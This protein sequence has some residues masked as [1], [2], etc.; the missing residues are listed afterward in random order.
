MMHIDSTAIGHPSKHQLVAFAETLVDKRAPV[1]ALLAAHVT[2]CPVCAHEVKQIR[3]SFELAA[4]AQL[5]EPS[6][7]LTQQILLRARNERQQSGLQT[8][9][10]N[11]F[12]YI[13][14]VAACLIAAFALAYFSFTTALNDFSPERKPVLQVSSPENKP[15]P[16][17]SILK[18]ETATLQ[19]LASAMALR[20]VPPTSPYEQDRHRFI[21]ALDADLSAARTALERNPGCVRANQVMLT[22][23]KRQLEGLRSLYLD[24]KL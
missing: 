15:I 12:G 23:V 7:E 3:A 18:K 6:C 13:T 22:S 4:L 11:Y 21:N 1:S 9:S 8:D 5:P 20:N 10:G 17:N 14:Q 19:A 16:A 2:G 24:H